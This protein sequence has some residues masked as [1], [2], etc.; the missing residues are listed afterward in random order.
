VIYRLNES[1]TALKV[2]LIDVIPTQIK[3]KGEKAIVLG[4]VAVRIYDSKTFSDAYII[5]KD[6]GNLEIIDQ[7][8]LVVNKDWVSVYTFDGK[9]IERFREFYTSMVC[10]F[11]GVCAKNNQL[12]MR[13]NRDLY[14]FK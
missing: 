5:V 8:F 7:F 4:G 9:L 6:V 12:L 2:F 13:T 14:H 11:T 3:V 10:R 1:F